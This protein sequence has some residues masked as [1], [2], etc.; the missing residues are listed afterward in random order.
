MQHKIWINQKGFVFYSAEWEFMEFSGQVG[1]TC[2]R[3]HSPETLNIM[4]AT[5]HCK[6]TFYLPAILCQGRGQCKNDNQEIITAPCVGMGLCRAQGSAVCRAGCAH[7]MADTELL[8]PSPT[9]QMHWLPELPP[10]HCSGAQLSLHCTAALYC[11]NGSD[12]RSVWRATWGAKEGM[13]GKGKFNV[14]REILFLSEMGNLT[15]K[16]NI[17]RPTGLL[18][19]TKN[20]CWEK[21]KEQQKVWLLLEKN[22]IYVCVYIY[23]SHCHGKYGKYLDK[24][25]GI[26]PGWWFCPLHK[27][28]LPISERIQ[29]PTEGLHSLHAVRCDK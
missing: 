3:Q 25:V 15:K 19:F 4:M 28:S 17:K 23:I 29:T 2:D 21:F 10:P 16:G 26:F 12:I 9:P 18:Q 14:S 6:G 8:S 11:F 13:R 1:K 5:A 7:S 22:I 20:C 27:L 24:K